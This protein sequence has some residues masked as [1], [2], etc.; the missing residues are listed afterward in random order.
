MRGIQLKFFWL[1]KEVVYYVVIPMFIIL[2]I[3]FIFILIYRRKKGTYYY[4]YVVDYV[5]ST[6][7]IIFCGLLFCLLLGYCI[8]TLQLL[9]VNRI[10][11]AYLLLGIFL[12]ILPII[13]FSFLVYVI[14]VYLKNLK[15]KSRLDA[16]LE[17]K[18]Q[19]KVQNIQET[20][21]NSIPTNEIQ[22]QNI[23]TQVNK[24][25]MIVNYDIEPVKKNG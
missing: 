22:N 2:F 23:E 9:I 4:N 16:D 7:G 21:E 18:E 1:P 20:T 8:A 14:I 24:K 25:S 10:I 13:P 5:Y 6:L 11:Y 17:N 15:R 3:Y 19:I 12:V